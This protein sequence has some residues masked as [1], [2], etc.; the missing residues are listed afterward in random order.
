MFQLIFFLN[1]IITC[2]VEWRAIALTMHTLK[3][4]VA[5]DEESFIIHFLKVTIYFILWSHYTYKVDANDVHNCID[6]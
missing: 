6:K 5:D 2:G 3:T 4:Q 1:D